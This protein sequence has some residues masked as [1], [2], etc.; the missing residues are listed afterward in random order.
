MVQNS[1]DK[2]LQENI[3]KNLRAKYD[4][5]NYHKNKNL[6]WDNVTK[7]C[8]RYKYEYRRT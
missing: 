2:K 7:S 5:N 6:E 3:D 1:A 8:T 4:S